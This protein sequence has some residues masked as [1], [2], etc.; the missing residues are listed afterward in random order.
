MQ[1][2]LWS[3]QILLALQFTC[4]HRMPLARSRFLG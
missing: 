3:A 1:V 4:G 2:G